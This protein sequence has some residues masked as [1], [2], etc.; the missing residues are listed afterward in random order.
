MVY[1]KKKMRVQMAKK[2]VKI[3]ADLMHKIADKLAVG[4]TLKDIL[5]S[6]NMPTYQGVMQAVL[7]DDDLFEI[8]RRGRVAQSEWH[9]DQII[10]L[11]QEPLPEFED[12]RLANAEVQRR[13]LEIDSLKWTLARNMPWGVRDKKEDAPQAQAFTISWAGK[14][15]E[16]NALIDDDKE[17]EQEVVKH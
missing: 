4:E 14:D 11:A 16:V 12:N 9:T 3:D 6:P 2:P 8:Y 10:R 17:E 15:V 1:Q 13:R 7:R 5:K